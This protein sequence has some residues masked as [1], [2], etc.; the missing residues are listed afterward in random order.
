MN[1]ETHK[2]K[3][4]SDYRFRC[5]TV[6]S[7]LSVNRATTLT[8]NQAI[9]LLDLESQLGQYQSLTPKQKE[10]YEDFKSRLDSITANQK[11]QFLEWEKKLKTPLLTDK[12]KERIEELRAKRDAPPELTEGVKSFCRKIVKEI[13][14]GRVR[15]VWTRPL[16]KGTKVEST[17]ISIASRFLETTILYN[18]EERSLKNDLIAGIP[19]T[20][21]Q[22]DDEGKKVVREFKSPYTIDTFPM[23]EP[24][25][26]DKSGKYYDQVQGYISLTGADYAELI[27]V[28]TDTPDDMLQSIYFSV[29]R[30]MGV[31]DLPEDVRQEIKQKHIYIDIPLKNRV[32]IYRIEKDPTFEERV[33]SQVKLCK[34]YMRE[35]IDEYDFAEHEKLKA[36]IQG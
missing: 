10:K 14:T 11:A 24:T 23:F 6:N 20:F 15:R 30:E 28:L 4:I 32:K 1:W 25:W 16:E 7:I 33:E 29:A 18:T 8:E 2:D 21:P 27:Y 3:L 13:C 31:I 17:S 19:D 35:I 12:K 22:I 9:E 5:H 36:M 34:K 26:K